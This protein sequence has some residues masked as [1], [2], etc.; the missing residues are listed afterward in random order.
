MPLDAVC[1]QAVVEELSRGR[2]ML[3][4]THDLREAEGYLPLSLNPQAAAENAE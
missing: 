1:L 2:T 4:V 3:L